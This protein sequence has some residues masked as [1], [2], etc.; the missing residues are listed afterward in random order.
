[1]R[2]AAFLLLL[3]LLPACITDGAQTQKLQAQLDAESQR[4]Q[5]LSRQIELMT[6]TVENSRGPQAS[7]ANEV[8]ALRQEVARLNGRIEE[9]QQRVGEVQSMDAGA[10]LTA[11]TTRVAYL[12]RYLGITSTS[13]APSNPAGAQVVSTPPAASSAAA[14]PEPVASGD[15]QSVYDTGLRLYQQKSYQAARD[16]FE[17]L[18]RRF[19]NHKLAESARFQLGETLYADQKYEEAILAYNQYL[20]DFPNGKS[21]PT[22]TLKQGMS[23]AALGDN[24]S[25]KIVYDKLIKN[26]PNSAE[27]KTAADLVAKMPS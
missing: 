10:Q 24:R 22:A 7:L 18:L 3:L 12:E 25:A 23:F 26:Y 13:A 16:R 1:M 11:L 15:A 4:I 21:V 6:N 27:A 20:K 2:Y 17:D 5:E 19:P 14:N 9:A 8:V